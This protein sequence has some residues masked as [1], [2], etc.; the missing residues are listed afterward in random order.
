MRPLRLSLPSTL[1]ALATILVHGPAA[2]QD[3]IPTLLERTGTFRSRKVRESSGV[4][5]SRAHP[6]LL[7][8]HND[9]GDGPFLY[10]VNA[11]G[12]VLGVF[13]V[14]GAQAEDWEDIALGPC[15]AAR[16]RCLYIGDIGD[17]GEKR[18]SV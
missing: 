17:N 14:D 6:G 16:R 13:R 7:C 2:G 9:S 18:K 1:A 3:S 8:T 5:V 4:V 10:A 12:D 11:S 15:P